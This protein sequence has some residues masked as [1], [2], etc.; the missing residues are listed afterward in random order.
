LFQI[1]G[2]RLLRVSRVAFLL[3]A[4]SPLATVPVAALRAQTAAGDVK[5]LSLS[6][7]RAFPLRTDV[8]VTRVSIALPDIADVIVISER[9]VLINC[10]KTGETDAIIWFADGT[11]AHY[12]IRVHS[13]SDR[14]Q[15]AIGVKFAEVRRDALRNIGVSGVWRDKNTR[16][17]SGTFNTDNVI[18]KA[19]GDVTLPT[20][21]RFLTVL[22]NLGT[23]NVLAFLDAEEQRGNARL[24]AEP[25]MIAGNLEQASFLAGGEVP[26]PVVQ[27]GGSGTGGNNGISIQYREF[28][29]RLQFMGEIISDSLIKLTLTPEVSSLD[30][31]NGVV[32][33]GFRI[34]A[35][36]TR[37]ITSTIDV[38]RDQ[39]L[40]VSGLFSDDEQKVR[41]GMPFL[42]DIPILGQLFSSTTFQRNESELVVVVTP[43]LIDPMNP[44]EQDLIRTLPDTARPAID[45]LKKRLPPKKNP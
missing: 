37:R 41:T 3:A 1:T 22:S 21:A 5:E 12:R 16:A 14:K 20:T 7:G 9:E 15:I 28:G 8:N 27:G 11:R 4:V 43:V 2:R 17:G 42:K 24:L 10:F 23:D 19:T 36:R 45:A 29:I 6:A 25:N 44:R 40:I 35:F 30:F 39:S 18:D 33:S 34:P 32:L 38:R 13:P 31:G 26:I